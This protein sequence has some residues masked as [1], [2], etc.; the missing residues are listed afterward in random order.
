MSNC[1]VPLD[2]PTRVVAQLRRRRRLALLM[3]RAY[4]ARHARGRRHWQASSQVTVMMAGVLA[5]LE[6]CTS[7]A[8][9]PL[10]VV[11]APRVLGDACCCR[12]P[13]VR[14][15]PLKSPEIRLRA[16]CVTHGCLHLQPAVSCP[17]V[18]IRKQNTLRRVTC[19]RCTMTNAHDSRGACIAASIRHHRASSSPARPL[20]HTRQTL[21]RCARTR[22]R[23][24]LS[25]P[26]N[27]QSRLGARRHTVP[28]AV[29]PG[30]APSQTA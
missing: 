7:T 15:S 2:S 3:G 8:V 10:V 26:P 1:V 9:P 23:C 6:A 27:T 25:W 22:G 5:A 29:V 21:P 24:R 11:V 13:E 19:A 16:A 20:R 4:A 18:C 17:T 14:H 12:A 30:C 28:G